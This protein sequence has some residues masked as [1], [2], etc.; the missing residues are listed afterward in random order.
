[1]YGEDNPPDYFRYNGK[2]KKNHCN[3]QEHAEDSFEANNCNTSKVRSKIRNTIAQ[4]TKL[5]K[6]IDLSRIAHPQLWALNLRHNLDVHSQS[7][8]NRNKK[9]ES[10]ASEASVQ[11]T[12]KRDSVTQHW[13]KKSSVTEFDDDWQQL[14]E[15]WTG[16]DGII[17]GKLQGIVF[18]RWRSRRHP[19]KTL[20][21]Q[22]ARVVCLVL[23]V[24][25][26]NPN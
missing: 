8:A 19:T 10:S 12:P 7:G 20:L 2:G 17:D 23:V 9:C 13:W 4:S 3:T 21:L 6:P 1:M 18:Q 25:Y 5:A 11:T 16:T 26:W 14:L 24:R 22:Y 15:D